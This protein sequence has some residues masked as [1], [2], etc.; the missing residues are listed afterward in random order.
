MISGARAVIFSGKERRMELTRKAVSGMMLTLLFIGMLTLT[1]DIQPA[2]S[3]PTTIIVPDDYPTIQAAINHANPRDTVYVR[4]GTYYENVVVTKNGVALVGENRE[5]TVIDGGT[6]TVVKVMANNTI[7]TN[8]TIQNGYAGIYSTSVFNC[9]VS[10]NNVKNSVY[11]IRLVLSSNCSVLGNTATSSEYGINLHHSSGCSVFDNNVI[12][13]D[14]GIVL[15]YYC[16]NCSVF[17]NEAHSNNWQGIHLLESSYCYVYDN[18]STNNDAGVCLSESFN[19]S[20][21]RNTAINND[22]SGIG[23]SLSYGT[24]LRDNNMTGN[25]GDFGVYGESLE[26]YIHDIDASNIV[27]GKPIVYWV[28]QS[29]RQVPGNAGYV[30]I[31]NSTNIA[32]ENL[33]LTNKKDGVLLVGTTNSTVKNVTTSNNVYGIRLCWSSHC[34]VCGN[35]ASNNGITMYVTAGICL[36][37]C[38]N[39]YVYGNN[40]TKNIGHG[41]WLW[42]SPDNTVE[43]NTI[44]NNNQ[45]I[46]LDH[47]SDCNIYGN[48]A[49]NNE[50][51]G[52]QLDSSSGCSVFGNIANNSKYAGIDLGHSSCHCSVSNNNANNND[53]GICFSSSYCTVYGNTVTNNTHAGIHLSASSNCSIYGNNAKHN[54][55]GIRLDQSSDNRVFYNNFIENTFQADVSGGLGNVWDDDYPSGGNYWSDY[56]TGVDEFSGPFQNE[57]GSD[58]IGD[59]P[60]TIDAYNQDRYPLM[61]PFSFFNAGTWHEITYHVHTVSN[62]TVPDFYFSKDNKLISFNV[63]GQDD[64]VGFCRVT[65]PNELLWCNSPEQWEVWVNNT[66]IQDRKVIPTTY[67]T[68]IYFTYNHTT[69]AVRIV[70]TTVIPIPP[71]ADAG[72]DQSVFEGMT[73]AFDGSNSTDNVGI[74]SYTWSFVDVTLKTLTGVQPKYTFNNVGDFEVTLNVSDYAGNWDTDI[75]R[76]HVL[77]ETTKPSIGTVSQEPEVPDDGQKVTITV[78][79]TDEES[80]VYNVT[81]WYSMDGDETWKNVTM[82][83]KIGNTYEGEIPGLPAG[84]TVQYKVIACDYAENIAVNDNAGQYYVYTVIPEFPSLIILLLF[85]VATLITTVI[86]KR[87]KSICG[88]ERKIT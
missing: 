77:P 39:C 84:T 82:H 11:G 59:Q 46:C 23:L 1:F 28:N 51:F 32:V 17:G 80:G 41:I 13:N 29:N 10:G 56:Y 75:M 20:V 38:S 42:Y 61:G 19:C 79:V 57:T 81:L 65:I 14:H 4:A 15:D 27:N 7:I 54:W 58:G 74:A 18:N 78:D 6:D 63:T 25:G 33:T 53:Y 49:I 73:I 37:E 72:P 36:Y 35:T 9:S 5:T 68:Y 12:N 76:V 22:C 85:M 60:Y 3:E 66:L 47:S 52:I 2:K 30:T 21:C 88:P 24:V 44:T 40:A 45:G 34:S 55:Y 31:V 69:K 62:S 67:Y 43:N 86:S 87:K 8:F 71:N 64:T 16:S 26:D 50:W 48:T 70:G 83:K